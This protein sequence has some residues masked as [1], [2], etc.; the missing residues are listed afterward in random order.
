MLFSQFKLRDDLHF[1]KQT[2]DNY[3]LINLKPNLK[4]HGIYP[5]CTL[6]ST[7]TMTKVTPSGVVQ[8]PRSIIYQVEH[9]AE[10]NEDI[11]HQLF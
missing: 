2:F 11:F 6:H 5:I 3:T 7:Y 1:L 4:R 10:I 9:F 8:Q